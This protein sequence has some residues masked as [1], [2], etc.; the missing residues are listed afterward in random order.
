[1]EDNHFGKRFFTV[2]THM[3]ADHITGTGKL[4]CLLPGCQSMI[5]RSSGAKADILLNPDD[6]ISFG[7]HNLR[8][9]PTPG[10]TEGQISSFWGQNIR[11][12]GSISSHCTSPNIDGR[13]KINLAPLIGKHQI[14]IILPLSHRYLSHLI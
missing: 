2:N 4:K 12:Y 13:T 3:H 1:M 7:R 10:H 9:L 14:I 6:Q 5:S 8:V 11:T